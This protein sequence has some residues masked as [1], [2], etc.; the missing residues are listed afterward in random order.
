MDYK[1]PHPT[2]S[3]GHLL[4][5]GEGRAL[6]TLS[7]GERVSAMCRRV[8]GHFTDFG[9]G[10]QAALRSIPDAFRRYVVRGLSRG[11]LRSY[12]LREENSRIRPVGDVRAARTR[13]TVV[14]DTV[15]RKIIARE[16]LDQVTNY[17]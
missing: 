14:R 2:S 1:T 12:F 8:G 4:P 7:R 3:L 16:L 5:R 15:E 9:C 11:M 6:P 13:K 17:A 10:R